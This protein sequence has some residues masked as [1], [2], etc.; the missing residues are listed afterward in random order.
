MAS[1]VEKKSQNWDQ[2]VKKR[3]WKNRLYRKF[4][5]AIQRRIKNFKRKKKERGKITI[6]R[7][8]EKVGIGITRITEI[9]DGQID[10]IWWGRNNIM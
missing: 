6:R 8:I 1:W 10:L 5:Q 4:V 9:G 7:K 2:K 3:K